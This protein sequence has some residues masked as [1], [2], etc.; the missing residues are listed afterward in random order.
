MLFF[1]SLESSA[2]I[3]AVSTQD[4]SLIPI[5]EARFG[6]SMV[7]DS[8]NK[9][10][11][12]FGG[13]SDYHYVTSKDD[14]WTYDYVNNNWTELNPSWGPARRLNSAMVYDSDNQL[15]ILFGGNS[16]TAGWELD[17]TWI[18]DIQTNSWSLSYS[19]TRP[20]GRSDHAMAYDP[21]T[22]KTIL[23]G[24]MRDVGDTTYLLNDTWAFDYETDTWT[25]LEPTIA[26]QERYGTR[27]IYNSVD[28]KIVLYGGNSFN[29]MTDDSQL[30]TFNVNT[31]TWEPLNSGESSGARYWYGLSFNANQNELIVFGGTGLGM[32]VAQQSDTWVYS[33]NTNQWTNVTTNIH[34]P[35]SSLQFMVYNEEYKKVILFGGENF[36]SGD[37]F[38]DVWIYDTITKE[39]TELDP[40]EIPKIDS[41]SETTKIDSSSETTKIDSSSEIETQKDNTNVTGF[42]GV[43]LITGLLIPISFIKKIRKVY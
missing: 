41:S 25:E 24:G 23:F 9:N 42:N 4:Q 31:T 36:E 32:E 14:L 30:W 37:I 5:P 8:V 13:S 19:I 2:S 43:I 12:L 29:N 10:I 27:M 11:F 33:F 38:G 16:I 7:Y 20:P 40:G 15:I 17:D 26:P 18:Y 35:V 1:Q 6:H 39:W 28:N 3:S 34:P 21:N 22:K